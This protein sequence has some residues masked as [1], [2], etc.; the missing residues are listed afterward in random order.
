MKWAWAELSSSWL[1][2]GLT[3]AIVYLLY[4]ILFQVWFTKWSSHFI[5]ILQTYD[6]NTFQKEQE[7]PSPPEPPKPP[8][9]M[10]SFPLSIPVID[11]FMCR[12][13]Q[14]LSASGHKLTAGEEA[15]YDSSAAE[16]LWRRVW[17]VRWKHLCRRCYIITFWYLGDQNICVASHTSCL[18]GNRWQ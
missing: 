16:S 9:S 14:F 7:P 17:G 6:S 13:A 10:T 12:T 5:H 1:N 11:T 15:G 2:L 8:V 18:S 3:A 4:K